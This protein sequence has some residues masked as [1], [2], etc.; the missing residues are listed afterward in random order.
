MTYFIT[1]QN[2]PEL[3]EKYKD[4]DSIK[5]NIQLDNF[6]DKDNHTFHFTFPIE[7]ILHGHF[8]EYDSSKEIYFLALLF[9]KKLY[10]IHQCYGEKLKH[11]LNELKP[12]LRD[13]AN[14]LK[15]K[16]NSSIFDTIFI[17]ILNNAHSYGIEYLDMLLEVNEFNLNKTFSF[18]PYGFLED[19]QIFGYTPLMVA[20]S[21]KYMQKLIEKGAKLDLIANPVSEYPKYELY[22]KGKDFGYYHKL[23]KPTYTKR[24][25]KTALEIAILD[26]KKYAIDLL[27]EH[28]NQQ[29][30]SINVQVDDIFE[31]NYQ[32]IVATKKTV[33]RFNLA[34]RE[35][36]A[37]NPILLNHLEEPEFEDIL[38]F[39][40]KNQRD[41]LSYAIKYRSNLYLKKLINIKH[42]YQKAQEKEFKLN[43]HQE[44][45]N[46]ALING[47]KESV[48]LLF[49][50][51]FYQTS[52]KSL[53]NYMFYANLPDLAEKVYLD[54]K[55]AF[56]LE[57]MMKPNYFKLL[58]QV[59]EDGSASSMDIKKA[60][61]NLS[62]ALMNQSIQQPLYIRYKLDNKFYKS[63]F[64][65]LKAY[66]EEKI[67]DT[68]I[69]GLTLHQK[70]R[71]FTSKYLDEVQKTL[72]D[73]FVILTKE[74]PNI[75][76]EAF[77][78]FKD[79]YSDNPYFIEKEKD[80]LQSMLLASETKEGKKGRSK[81]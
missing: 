41:F 17:H 34:I 59:L 31:K 80:Y 10:A 15:I 28:M 68:F 54:D 69:E 74:F 43:K 20:K 55:K 56:S 63:L 48:R 8:R 53:F 40:D 66:P 60:I 77:G 70:T 61:I 30:E 18:N 49:E 25:G 24:E 12:F 11:E 38:N 6:Y 44:Y 36:K 39:T 7:S 3:V 29:T 21:K 58:K 81:I 78:K 75:E 16:Q 65:L 35:I 42:I 52:G 47:N 45:L 37:N 9:R 64:T 73:F 14:Y 5:L 51:K 46:D 71:Q 57:A 4:L 1:H 76:Q 62:L 19:A 23:G 2:H 22:F 67:V 27:K 72:F 26:K 32:K 33:T 50:H 79:F 13:F